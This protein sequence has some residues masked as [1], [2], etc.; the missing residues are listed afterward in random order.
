M[1]DRNITKI[2]L[3]KALKQEGQTDWNRVEKSDGDNGGDDFDWSKAVIVDPP[4]KKM[5]SI[6]LDAEVLEFFKADGKGYQTRINAVLRSFMAAH[7][8]L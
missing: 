2:T 4:Q 8:H 7:N 5:V 1:N 3:N 6:R